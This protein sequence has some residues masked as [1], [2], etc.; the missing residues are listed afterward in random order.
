MIGVLLFLAFASFSS[1]GCTL[2]V[3]VGNTGLDGLWA[4]LSAWEAGML[5][6][7]P[8]SATDC[9]AE[10]TAAGYPMVQGPD[11]TNDDDR[12]GVDA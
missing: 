6:L 9:L 10:C 8:M 4:D 12:N 7:S 1:A 3:C 5:N 2:P 11:C